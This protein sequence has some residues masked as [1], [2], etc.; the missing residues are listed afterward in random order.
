MGAA[1]AWNA[2]RWVPRRASRRLLRI[3]VTC[4][5]TVEITLSPF[6]GLSFWG[7]DF[8][9][10]SLPPPRGCRETAVL[11]PLLDHA[12]RCC[13]HFDFQAFGKRGGAQDRTKEGCCEM[14]NRVLLARVASGEPFSALRAWPT[15]PD[16]QRSLDEARRR[17]KKS[18]QQSPQ[19]EPL[20]SLACVCQRL[21][22]A[23]SASGAEAL[24]RAP[25]ECAQAALRRLWADGPC[26]PH[27][28][29]P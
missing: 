17:A 10:K 14:P 24:P 27:V 2:R 16:P 19:A 12:S 22:A 9:D 21:P 7:S 20:L 5:V 11:L 23:L 28:Q 18:P 26:G 8:R 13:K 1:S 29:G 4:R 6:F 25:S 15:F 3:T